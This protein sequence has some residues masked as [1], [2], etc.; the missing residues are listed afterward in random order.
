MLLILHVIT[1]T[2]RPRTEKYREIGLTFTEIGLTFKYLGKTTEKRIM[3][4]SMKFLAAMTERQKV[5]KHRESD[6]HT[7][8]FDNLERTLKNRIVALT[9]M[10][11]SAEMSEWQRVRKHRDSDTRTLNPKKFLED[12]ATAANAWTILR[13]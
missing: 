9:I 12:S 3:A 8:T 7:L 1:V 5:E 4:I 13:S 2:R 6:G 10:F 11:S